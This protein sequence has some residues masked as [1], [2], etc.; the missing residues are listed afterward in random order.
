MLLHST[1]K[2]CANISQFL[3]D[4]SVSPR[5]DVSF[6]TQ[7]FLQFTFCL[8]FL[9]SLSHLYQMRNDQLLLTFCLFSSVWLRKAKFITTKKKQKQKQHFQVETTT[10][11]SIHYSLVSKWRVLGGTILFSFL[12]FLLNNIFN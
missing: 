5:P 7:H 4:S 9:C 6:F 2:K 1:W 8:H 3:T 12:F 10:N 11:H